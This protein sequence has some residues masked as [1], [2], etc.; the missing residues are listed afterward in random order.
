V[1]T[2]SKF[3]ENYAVGKTNSIAGSGPS[4]AKIGVLQLRDTDGTVIGTYNYVNGGYGRG[5]IPAGDYKVLSSQTVRPDQFD[6]MS[7]DGVAYKFPVA[8]G[9]GSTEIPD[10][11][12]QSIPTRDNPNG[13]PRDG[14][15]I[16]P[17]GGS[18]GTMGCIGIQGDG[19]VQKDF[20]EKL[21]YLINKNNGSYPL[22]FDTA[23]SSI[24]PAQNTE[25][26]PQQ[27]SPETPESSEKPQ[28]ASIST[29]EPQTAKAFSPEK[30]KEETTQPSADVPEQA[31]EIASTIRNWK[32]EANKP[33][34]QTGKFYP[35]NK[36]FSD[37]S[38]VKTLADMMDDY[39]RVKPEWRKDF[40]NSVVQWL[41]DLV[42]SK[43]PGINNMKD[44]LKIEDD[45]NPKNQQQYRSAV[46]N[47]A[48]YMNPAEQP[49][50]AKAFTPP[51][52]TQ[53]QPAGNPQNNTQTNE[54][55]IVTQPQERVYKHKI[56]KDFIDKLNQIK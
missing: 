11:R 17:D 55:N 12:V 41:K 30:N 22:K 19:N 2:F 44:I 39:S 52:E 10:S 47:I 20:F 33:S 14:I 32:W 37:G 50:T 9:S 8:T 35:A 1:V 36:Q 43:H 54:P 27:T 42:D 24:G 38:S 25:E 13:G 4:A 31:K 23:E 48:N 49:Q 6:A 29:S 51:V 26:P 21:S 15:M 16:H 56:T 18:R 34:K 53:Q 40:S 7:I 5:Y 3:L 45:I 28:Q 46:N